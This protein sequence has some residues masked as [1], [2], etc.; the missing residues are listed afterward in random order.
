MPITEKNKASVKWKWESEDPVNIF[1]RIRIENRYLAESGLVESSLSI[2]HLDRVHSG[3]WNC[4]LVSDEGNQT[5]TISV[6]VISEDT[7]YCP[8]TVTSD[9]KGVYTWPKTVIGYTVELQCVGEQLTGMGSRPP[10]R[11]Q[12]M[13]T[14]TGSWEFL[15]T[16]VCPYVSETTKILEQFAKGSVLESAKRLKNFTSNSKQLRDKMDVVFIS[17]TI[18]NYLEYVTKERESNLAVEEFRVNRESFKGIACTWYTHSGKNSAGRLFHCST[19]ASNSTASLRTKVIEASIH[20]PPSLFYQ[21]EVLQSRPV[22][23]SLQLVVSMYENNRLFPRILPDSSPQDGR[24]IVSCVIGTKLVGVEV[25]SL[26]H[27]VFIMLRAPL[28]H[29]SAGSPKPVWWDSSLNNGTGGWS[30]TG[31]QL[32][33]LQHGLLVFQCNRLGYF[34]LMQKDVYLYDHLG[35]VAGAKFRFSHPAIYVGSIVCV[36]S[37][38]VPIVTYIMCYA[39]IQMSKKTKHSLVNTWV[40]LALL[41]FM[42]SS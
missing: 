9:N 38:M 17:K 35:R 34:G 37:L 40:A 3:K 41:C 1:D 11:A 6:I 13:C 18:E 25:E 10:A 12:Y 16:S 23:S 36:V 28:L 15:N 24:D 4:Q 27:P 2:E 31:C 30:T 19:S 5:Q 22:A 42:Y 32:S 26:T 21:L 8:Q 29:D 39:S 14:E 7:Q 20:V 33:Q